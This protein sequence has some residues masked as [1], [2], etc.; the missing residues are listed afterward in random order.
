M[1]L[2]NNGIDPAANLRAV[3][4]RI[5][6]AREKAIAPAA[7]T[8]LV[9][10]SKGHESARILPVLEAGQRIFGEN[11]VQEA[12]AKWPAL[13]QRF[14]DTELH[15]VG[16]LQTNK[17]PDAAALFDYVHSLDRERL[18]KAFV[19]ERTKHGR[20]PKLFVQVNTGEEPQKAGIAPGDAVAFARHCIEALELPVIGFMCIP[21]IGEEPS[22][23]FALLRK[24]ARELS[25]KFLSMGMSEDFETAIRFGATHVRIGTAI[26]GAR[27]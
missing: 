10:V 7:E 20:C 25:L 18:A 6:N 27:D 2:S 23:H 22:P 3:L 14:G 12:I 17:V 26:F 9:A 1:S 4:A 11:R 21:P 16:A 24:F 19:A 8:R 13:K 5:A 15:L